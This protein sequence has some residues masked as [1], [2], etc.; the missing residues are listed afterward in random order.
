MLWRNIAIGSSTYG[1][2]T[3]VLIDGGRVGADVDALPTLWAIKIKTHTPFGGVV[4]NITFRGTQLGNIDGT[5]I[6]VLLE[7]YN[8]PASR[9]APHSPRHPAFQTLP[10]ATCTCC[11]PTQR[12]TSER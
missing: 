7:P 11:A 4:R 10:S 12:A 1:N 6:Y 2:V 8:N 5:A 9:R 3:D